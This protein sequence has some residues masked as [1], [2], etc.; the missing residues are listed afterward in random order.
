[1]TRKLSASRFLASLVLDSAFFFP[2][3]GDETLIIVFGMLCLL[4]S[5][6]VG[7]T[8]RDL[9][10]KFPWNSFRYS[11]TALLWLLVAFAI[12]WDRKQPVLILSLWLVVIV[13]ACWWYF[14]DSAL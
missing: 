6:F 8:I 11:L 4:V 7:T 5:M 13:N 10:S 9:Y 2:L 3:L 12:M 1:M 14:R